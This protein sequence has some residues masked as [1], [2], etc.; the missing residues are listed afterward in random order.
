[1]RI[2]IHRGSKE[3][4][5]SCIELEC[6]GK[7]LILDLGIPLNAG[8]DKEENLPQIPGLNG[9]DPSLL[10]ILVTH[11]HIDHCGLLEY[12]SPEIQVGMS[13]ASRRILNAA[14]PF[15]RG[16]CSISSRGWTYRHGNRLRIDPFCVTP[17]LVD[18]SAYDSYSLLVECD[19]KRVFY[20][21]DF[22]AHGRKKNLFEH[23]IE[24]L[25]CGVDVL[26]MEG[27]SVGQSSSCNNF[28]TERDI[29]NHLMDLFSKAKGLVLVHASAQNIDR[30]VSIFRASKRTG[31]R[32]VIDLY[33]AAVLEATGNE[34]IPQSTW[35]DVVLY[36]PQI[37]RVQIKE[38]EL[39][40]LLKR[41]SENRIFIEDIKRKRNEFT[42]LFRPLHIQDLENCECLAG[43]I[44]VY[45]QWRGY[46][47]R[48]DYEMVK[49]W[50]L[51]HSIPF[52]SIHTSG[53]ASPAALQMLVEKVK[54]KRIVPVH[55]SS[56]EKYY[57]LF[58]NVEVHK[59]G[60]WWEV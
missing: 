46:W 49:D 7:R 26:L 24:V 12:V 27:T 42:L 15:L 22:R 57:R 59:D 25:P 52:Y 48:G 40:G 35:R 8:G 10:G 2:C 39:F 55:T 31:R 56:P 29:E 41:H 14:S 36:V 54:P 60:Q 6:R 37:Q 19:G 32:L 58:P 30:V 9:S 13:G 5:G 21:G 3:I 18:H 50:L 53:H 11:S 34:N 28:Q 1:M 38:N 45:S 43:A 23:L 17:L 44:Y 20:T 47:Q 33:T 16:G 51:R 4:G